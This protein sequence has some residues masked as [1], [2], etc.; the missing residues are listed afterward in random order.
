MCKLANEI[1]CSNLK[2][3]YLDIVCGV[4]FSAAS[5][6]DK[7]RK[8]Y[9]FEDIGSS[10]RKPITVTV[11][12]SVYSALVVLDWA[13][14]FD[15]ISCRGY[16]S[17]SPWPLLGFSISKGVDTVHV[18]RWV[19]GFHVYSA[20][21]EHFNTQG[22]RTMVPSVFVSTNSLLVCYRFLGC[23]CSLEIVVHQ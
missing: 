8:A 13:R 14:V 12:R 16:N 18:K 17:P 21:E 1:Q 6:I 15:C 10:A 9:R 5:E 4:I 11:L 20:W 23:L 22:H 7:E 2:W 3:C 19:S